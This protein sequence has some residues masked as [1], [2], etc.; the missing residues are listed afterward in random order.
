MMGVGN[1]RLLPL[2][3]F[4]SPCALKKNCQGRSPF[5]VSFAVMA[6][7]VLQ[8]LPIPGMVVVSTSLAPG[9]AIEDLTLAFVTLHDDEWNDQVIFVLL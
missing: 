8:G 9:K 1:V 5:N 6:Y 3:A 4:G 2:V 7:R